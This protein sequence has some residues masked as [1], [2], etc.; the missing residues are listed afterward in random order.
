MPT[1]AEY[2]LLAGASYFDTR[3]LRESLPCSGKLDS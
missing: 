1:T 2:A 3:T